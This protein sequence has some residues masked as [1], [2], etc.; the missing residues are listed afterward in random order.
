MLW[1]KDLSMPDQYYVLPLFMGV[2]MF[3]QMRMT[4]TPSPTKEAETQQKIFQYGM[5]VFLTFLAFKW[6][7]GLLLYWSMSNLFSIIQQSIVNRTKK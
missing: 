3:I 6:P 2:T 4:K 5:P 1:F 7:S